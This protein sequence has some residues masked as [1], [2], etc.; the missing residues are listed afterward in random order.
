MII[1]K[2]LIKWVGGKSQIIKEILDK[3]PKEIDNY[4]EIFLGGGSVLFGLLNYQKEGI[5]KINGKLFAYDN[6]IALIYLY[7]NI[8]TNYLELYE[9]L[10]KII[11]EFN[12]EDDKESYYYYIRD[13]YNSLN[14]DKIKSIEGSSLFLF[15][16]KT[17]FRGL[18][19]E[20]RNGFNVPYGNY[21]N[22]EIINKNHLEE[23]HELIKE[24]EFIHQDFMISLSKSF[25]KNDFIYLDPP[26]YPE[27]SKSFVKY[28]KDGFDL[29]SHINLFKIINELNRNHLKILMNNSDVPIIREYFKMDDFRIITI[30][31]KRRINSKNPQSTTNEL[32]IKN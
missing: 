30:E 5:I 29:N 1:S 16:N 6:N 10:M 7:K 4:H 32:I 25:N 11:E 8:Q 24:V 27:N 18:F 14:I 12:K 22:P 28:N 15:L 3:F 20:S 17:C 19:R 13:K 2:P 9:Y 21:K 23:I 26:Y 31:C